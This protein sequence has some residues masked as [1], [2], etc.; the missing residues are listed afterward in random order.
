[1]LLQRAEGIQRNIGCNNAELHQLMKIK[2]VSSKP[3]NAF[4]LQRFLLLRLARAI[5]F[6]GCLECLL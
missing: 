3:L 6:F 1:M 2:K 5:F 4:L